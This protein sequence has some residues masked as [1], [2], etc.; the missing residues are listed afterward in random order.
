MVNLLAE[1]SGITMDGVADS[2]DEINYQMII[3]MDMI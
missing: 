2:P 3:S 1:C